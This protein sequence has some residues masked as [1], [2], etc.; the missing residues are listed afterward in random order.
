MTEKDKRQGGR[1][2]KPG[3]KKDFA[4]KPLQTL[5]QAARTRKGQA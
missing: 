5:R 1:P 4:K 2:F 3:A